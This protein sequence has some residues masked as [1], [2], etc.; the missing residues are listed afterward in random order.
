MA[1]SSAKITFTSLHCMLF[2]SNIK[3]RERALNNYPQT[4][5]IAT[6]VLRFTAYPHATDDTPPSVFTKNNPE[7]AGRDTTL[8]DASAPQLS[9]LVLGNVRQIKLVV[10]KAFAGKMFCK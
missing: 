4:A 9:L 7:S 5:N 3:R 1:N 6:S 8:S 2:I 10:A